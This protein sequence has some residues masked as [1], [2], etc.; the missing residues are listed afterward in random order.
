MGPVRSSLRAAPD[1]CTIGVPVPAATC[2]GSVKCGQNGFCVGFE[3]AM[4]YCYGSDTGCLWGQTDCSSDAD[5]L[6][7]SSWSPKYTTGHV[8]SCPGNA[9][10]GWTADAC[11]CRGCIPPARLRLRLHSEH[12]LSPKRAASSPASPAKD[13]CGKDN[14]PSRTH[15]YTCG[16]N[17][18]HRT[19]TQVS[20]R[21]CHPHICNGQ[22]HCYHSQMPWAEVQR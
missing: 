11:T 12:N 3:D 4:V 20:A 7:Y 17:P 6:K 8:M 10:A 16:Y 9:G 21:L 2:H 22:P 1:A 19:C 13:A 15:T 18:A 5:C 14:P